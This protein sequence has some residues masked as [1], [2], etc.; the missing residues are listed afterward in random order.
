[1]PGARPSGQGHESDGRVEI[2]R[3]LGRID[4]FDDRKQLSRSARS[5]ARVLNFDRAHAIL[6]RF[7]PALVRDVAAFADGSYRLKTLRAL[8]TFL[9]THQMECVAL[10][11]R[12]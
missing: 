6:D 9:M 12:G 1:V 8:D 3:A 10:L 7:V 4:D 2:V 5:V 11:E